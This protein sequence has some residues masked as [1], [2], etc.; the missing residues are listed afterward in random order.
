MRY[1]FDDN[2]PA[3]KRLEKENWFFF[4]DYDGTLAPIANTPELAVLPV[5]TRRCLEA[6]A[7]RRNCRIAVISGR[8]VSDLKRMIK[9]KDVIYIGNHGWEIAAKHIAGRPVVNKA[10]KYELWRIGRALKEKLTD[11]RGVNVENKRFT[12]SVHYRLA[13]TEHEQTVRRIVEQTVATDRA[14]GHLRIREGKKVLEVLPVQHW[15]KGSAA[16]LLY[17]HETLSNYSFTPV[18]IGDDRTDEDMFH[19]FK[20]GGLTIKVG[21]HESSAAEFYLNDHNDVQKF[22]QSVCSTN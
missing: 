2:N 17:D 1:L 21:T 4:L 15:N 8:S 3:L 11:I 18:C 16:R 10:T 20:S 14:R 19:A 12:L 13:E 7:A 22:L 5:E 9:I 6:L